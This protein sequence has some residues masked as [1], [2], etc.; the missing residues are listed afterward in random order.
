MYLEKPSARC[1]QI[2]GVISLKQTWADEQRAGISDIKRRGHNIEPSPVLPN[3]SVV[4]VKLSH[5]KLPEPKIGGRQVITMTLK[6]HKKESL[7]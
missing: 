2:S 3:S 5:P 4:A 7:I 6:N 1:K